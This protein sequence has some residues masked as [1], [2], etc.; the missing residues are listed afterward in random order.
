MN[1]KV[2]FTDKRPGDLVLRGGGQWHVVTG[3]D[4]MMT[5]EDLATCPEWELTDY[6]KSMGYRSE[7]LLG[8]LP[9][10]LSRADPRSASEQ[11]NER[12]AHGGGWMPQKGFGRYDP[13]GHDLYFEGDPVYRALAKAQLRDE[14]L[15]FYDCSWVAI[16]QPDGSFEVSRMD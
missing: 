12:Y 10:F 2:L 8:F 16:F 13:Q 9:L 3:D 11:F 4:D 5:V 14:T 1:R 6:A 15:V 7:T